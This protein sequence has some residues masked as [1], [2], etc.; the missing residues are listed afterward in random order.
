MAA[1]LSH[2]RKLFD[3]RLV[4]VVFGTDD[5]FERFLP[6]A[7]W[8]RGVMDRFDGKGVEGMMMK[9]AGPM[10]MRLIGLSPVRLFDRNE[11]GEKRPANG[12]TAYALRHH[13]EFYRKGVKILLAEVLTGK[14]AAPESTGRD[15]FSVSAYDG[16]AFSSLSDVRIN[17]TIVDWFKAKNFIAAYIPDYG[18]IVLNTARDPSLTDDEGRF[19]YDFPLRKGLDHLIAAIESASLAYLGQAKGAAAVRLIRRKELRLRRTE[20]R[21]VEK[22]LLLQEKEDH[23]QAVGAVSAGQLA[24]AAT[25]VHDGVFAFMDMAKSTQVSRKLTPREYFFVLNLCHEIVA[26]NT[27]KFQC[28]VDNIIGDAVFFET[29]SIFDGKNAPGVAARLM[30]MTCLLASVLEGINTL[31]RGRHELDR[32]MRVAGMLNLNDLELGFRAG[33]SLGG[34]LVGP[35][36]S[37]KRKIVTAIGGAV[38]RASRLESSGKINHI[39][40]TARTAGMLREAWIS[41]DTP[42]LFDFARDVLADRPGWA[43][44]TGF[45]FT[46]F[47]STWRGLGR[48]FIEIRD[49]PVCYKEFSITGTCLIPVFPESKIPHTCAG[50]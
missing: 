7:Q 14:G 34:A 17:S 25:A 35:L 24:M 33:M 20:A 4:G 39:H 45:S 3:A 30:R 42:V 16:S 10:I 5:T 2:A 37:R 19:V 43:R 50:I 26:E 32:D 22:D 47:Y 29:L 36:G 6:P 41:K 49:E 9:L 15:A 12:I 11:L 46:E 18:A 23:L 48:D 1:L 44:R 40:V 21:L 31:S 38:D 28:R 8:D 27:A 13:Q